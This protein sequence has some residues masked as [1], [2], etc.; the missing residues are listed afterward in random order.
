MGTY[1]PGKAFKAA[2][3]LT[4]STRDGL[5]KLKLGDVKKAGPESHQRACAATAW[6]L[7]NRQS[8]FASIVNAWRGQVVV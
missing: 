8:S 1:E 5:L 2:T 4:K 3:D 6:L 7:C